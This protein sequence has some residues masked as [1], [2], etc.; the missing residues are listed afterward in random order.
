MGKM[1]NAV[2]ILIF[3]C[4]QTAVT[5]WLIIAIILDWTDLPSLYIVYFL[6][7]GLVCPLSC[8]SFLHI[9]SLGLNFL[10]K[11]SS[12]AQD[13]RLSISSKT[14]ISAGKSFYKRGVNRIEINAMLWR[15][16]IRRSIKDLSLGL[17][18]FNVFYQISQGMRIDLRSSLNRLK[19]P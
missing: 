15:R 9:L 16:R 11:G 10:L 13:R 7:F 17:I 3:E 18:Q 12:P 2:I 5:L 14:R 1:W 4:S 6:L 8:L 19:E